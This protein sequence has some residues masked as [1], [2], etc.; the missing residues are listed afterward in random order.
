MDN[1]ED[2]LKTQE[3]GLKADYQELRIQ[4]E[5][6]EIIHG[7]PSKGMSSIYIPRDPEYFRRRR[8]LA[9]LRTL[10]VSSPSE[11]IIQA[12]QMVADQETSQKGEINAT[13]L[14]PLLL[15]HFLDRMGEIVISKHI[16]MLRWK[17][18]CSDTMKVEQVYQDY[19]TIIG[20]R[21]HRLSAGEEALLA[22]NDGALECAEFE[23]IQIY[24]RALIFK[25]QS[26][27]YFKQLINKQPQHLL[28]YNEDRDIR[29]MLS[30][31]LD[32]GPA[33][34]RADAEKGSS[35]IASEEDADTT[36]ALPQS[37]FPEEMDH[38]PIGPQE[39]VA[40]SG[41]SPRDDAET[42]TTGRSASESLR[43][44]DST[45]R[46]Y[47]DSNSPPWKSSYITNLTT[48][49]LPETSTGSITSYR[50]AIMIKD[51]E[52]QDVKITDQTFKF[53]EHSPQPPGIYTARLEGAGNPLLP[54]STNIQFTVAS[55][56]S[57]VNE[58]Y[59]GLPLHTTDIANIR[60]YLAIYLEAYNIEFNVHTIRSAADEMELFGVI[61]R[62]FNRIFLE[63]EEKR[64]FKTYDAP[65]AI[66][67]K[68]GLETPNRA[69]KKPANWLQFMKLKPHRNAYLVETMT[70]LRCAGN[71]DEILRSLSA[72]FKIN[73]PEVDSIFS[74]R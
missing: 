13:T 63:Q 17:R 33:T 50:P 10:Q 48:D 8:K 7:I 39:S 43:A 72:F 67:E 35:I 42:L 31:V 52:E 27:T 26:Q 54:T 23:D 53:S 41:Q 56:G 71:V 5:E 44:D 20:S 74:V 32:K 25:L 1:D 60:P 38:D 65:S 4:I 58:S 68:W 46:D 64:T 36:D 28:N 22:G 37:S 16:L 47:T 55:G 11:L 18:Y 24:W 70:K 45:K 19:L 57:V 61:N 6:N 34:V 15:Q 73:K 14:I 51:Q 59:F 66:S 40:E 21:A 62:N 12:D 30:L 29:Q 49:N 2:F 3:E 69:M 9:I